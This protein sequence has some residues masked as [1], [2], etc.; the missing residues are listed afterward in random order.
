VFDLVFAAAQLG[1]IWSDP[2]ILWGIAIAA[3]VMLLGTWLLARR[4]KG[5]MNRAAVTCGIVSVLLH[6]LLIALLP[7]AKRAGGGPESQLAEDPGAAATVRIRSFTGPELTDSASENASDQPADD[8]L[9]PPMPVSES[10]TAALAEVAE[11]SVERLRPAPIE[12]LDLQVPDKLEPPQTLNDTSITS[13]VDDLL[14]DMLASS[15]E[16]PTA[17]EPPAQPQQATTS[18]AFA[19]SSPS[20]AS[21]APFVPAS[22][23]SRATGGGERGRVIGEQVDDFANR[24][25]AARQRALVANGGDPQTEAAVE[26]GIV[27]LSRLQRE[28][29][30]WDP[31]TSGAGIERSVFGQNRGGAGSRSTTGITGLALLSML[32]GGNTHNEGNHQQSV[33]KGLQYLLGIQTPDG[34]LSGDADPYARTYCHGMAALAMCETAAMTRDAVALD[35]ARSATAYSRRLQH[36]TTGGWRYVAG[37][38]GDMSQL[39]WQAMVLVSGRSA[40]VEVPDEVIERTKLFLRSVRA[41]RTGG[42]ASYKPGEAPSRT[43]TAEAL[44]TRLLLGE[45]VPAN[46]IAEAEAYILAEPPGVGADNYYY[47]YYASLALHQLQDGAWEEWNEKMKRRLLATQLPDGSW[48]TASVWGGYG[49]KVYTTSMACLCLEVYY[50]HLTEQQR[51]I[52]K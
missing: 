11:Q 38:T 43:M 35:S 33:R 51:A 39:G 3:V 17:N 9:V 12:E 5:K 47:W 25:G 50:R 27:W 7:Y 16:N 40:G 42:L 4:R 46:E 8:A 22:V 31:V 36:P 13:A 19:S 2:R 28:D 29:G 49:G 10:F 37:D 15:S 32:G 1:D 26:A 30:S 18:A 14:L 48:G 20:P 52:A 21:N 24:R 44:A 23:D 45:N 41:G 34:S 6:V